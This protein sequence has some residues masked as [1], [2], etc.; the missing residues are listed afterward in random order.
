MTRARFT[1]VGPR[2][3]TAPVH[4]R[5]LPVFRTSGG[6]RSERSEYHLRWL[7]RPEVL[8]ARARA[9][10]EDERSGGWNPDFS[11]TTCSKVSS[12]VATRRALPWPETT[13]LETV[14]ADDSSNDRGGTP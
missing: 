11:A 12:V 5:Q 4:Y 7:H 3:P 2:V 6:T 13:T 10:M 9:F 14:S 1:V 8:E